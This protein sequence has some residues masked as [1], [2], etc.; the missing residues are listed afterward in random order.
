[1][2]PRSWPPRSGHALGAG[3]HPDEV[4]RIGTLEQSPPP[5]TSTAGQPRRVVILSAASP[6][7]PERH[8]LSLLPLSSSFLSLSFPPPSAP[9]STAASS[10]TDRSSIS[11]T[12]VA[13]PGILGACPVSP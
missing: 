13:F 12:S 10:P 4:H 6:R 9:A 8:F 3:R 5:A 7:G 2:R 1:W 11:N